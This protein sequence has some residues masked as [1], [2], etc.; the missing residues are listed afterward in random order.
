V[1][2]SAQKTEQ[3]AKLE[4]DECKLELDQTKETVGT[5]STK[6]KVCWHFNTSC[7]VCTFYHGRCSIATKRSNSLD[8]DNK[9]RQ[10]HLVV[11]LHLT[12]SVGYSS[13]VYNKTFLEIAREVFLH[14]S[15]LS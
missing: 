11:I 7:V 2:Q 4:K 15:C 3:K 9:H 10:C 14:A 5:I 12:S 13:M 8:N 6:L 1:L